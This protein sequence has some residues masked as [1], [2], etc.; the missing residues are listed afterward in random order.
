MCGTGQLLDG[1]LEGGFSHDLSF[2]YEGEMRDDEPAGLGRI[3][4]PRGEYTGTFSSGF[5][6]S[7]GVITFTDG[8]RKEVAVGEDAHVLLAFDSSKPASPLVEGL[9]KQTFGAQY[10]KPDP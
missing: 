8:K 10:R 6:S 1:T 9:L 7:P 3:K 4:M 2:S 5:P